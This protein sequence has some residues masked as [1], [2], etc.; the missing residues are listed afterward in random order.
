MPKGFIVR[1]WWGPMVL[2][3]Q[4]QQSRTGGVPMADPPCEVDREEAQE[5]E[6]CI[7]VLPEKLRDVITQTYI[8]GGTVEQLLEALHCC[9]WSYYTWLYKAYDQLL[10]YFNDVACGVPLPAIGAADTKR[11]TV[12]DDIPIIRTRLA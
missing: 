12:P 11:L 5:T 3:P 1:S 10:G 8:H 4:V 2:D 7:A 9:R 6:R